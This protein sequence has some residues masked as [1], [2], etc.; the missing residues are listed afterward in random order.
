MPFVCVVNIIW[1]RIFFWALAKDAGY[2]SL[3]QSC[4]QRGTWRPRLSSLFLLSS[5]YLAPKLVHII[6]IVSTYMPILSIFN[7]VMVS[8]STSSYSVIHSCRYS[9]LPS[10][11]WVLLLS[12]SSLAVVVI[13]SVHA[14]VDAAG[15]QRPL[16]SS[17]GNRSI[18]SSPRILL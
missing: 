9:A 15:I 7:V 10:S 14:S 13:P 16:L 17:K 18:S 4:M 8:A 2:C 12:A 1:V 5:R 11:R 3:N 6:L